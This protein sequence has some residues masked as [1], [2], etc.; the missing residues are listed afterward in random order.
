MGMKGK[1]LSKA[2]LVLGPC[3]NTPQSATVDS[4][5]QVSYNG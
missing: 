1:A 5:I 3:S 4:Q 2:S